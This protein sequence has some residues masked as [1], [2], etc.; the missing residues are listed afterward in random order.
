MTTEHA[1]PDELIA[2]Y[3]RNG[4]H[5]EDTRLA[6]SALDFEPDVLLRKGDEF[7][8]V[9]VKRSGREPERSIAEMRRLVERRPN[10]RFAVKLLTPQPPRSNDEIDDADVATRLSLAEDL[11]RDGHVAEAVLIAFIG[12]ETGLRRLVPKP[13]TPPSEAALPR[14]IRDAYE[15]EAISDGELRAINR[16]CEV[17]NRIAHGFKVDVSSQDADAILALARTVAGKADLAPAGTAAMTP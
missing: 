14:L 7:L 8:V 1:V 6:R 3:L 10:W 15:A 12:I 2:D 17:R 4:W 5:R 16:S 13:F 9:E 11:L